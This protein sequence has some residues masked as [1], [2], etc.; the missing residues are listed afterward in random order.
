M[1]VRTTK[2]GSGNIAVQIVENST[3]KVNVIKHIGTG[4]SP[5]Q[6][7]DLKMLAL[8]YISKQRIDAG[9]MSFFEESTLFSLDNLVINKAYKR[10]AYEFFSHVYEVNGFHSITDN[11]LKDLS[12]MRIIEPV[13]KEQS[14]ELMIKYFG[15]GYSYSTIHR[16]LFK[17]CNLKDEIELVA[18]EYARKNLNFDF[19]LVF[20]DVTTLYFETFKGDDL[21]KPGFSKDNK[22]IQ[23]QILI[24]L[25][26][27]TQGYPIGIEMFEGNKFEGHTFIPSILKLKEK[28]NIT[29]LTVVADAAMISFDNIKQL[30]SIGI[31]FIVGARLSKVDKQTLESISNDLNSR[32]GVY[33]SKDTAYGKLICDYSKKRASKDKSDREKQIR[34]AKSHIVRPSQARKPR[35]VKL[36]QKENLE[37]NHQLIAFDVLKEGIKGYYTN[38]KDVPE[39]LIVSRYH[40]LWHVEKSFRI[41]KSDLKA[42]PMFHRKKEMIL[43]HILIVFVSLCMSKSIEIKTGYSI[44]KVRDSVID[45]LDIEFTDKLTQKRVTKRMEFPNLEIYSAL[46]KI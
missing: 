14:I 43:A 31:S 1:K 36:S 11:L 13:S 37:L 2:T 9:E 4:R 20:Y 28:Y 30:S 8:E 42:R 18:V 39:N 7:E 29:T 40:D 22:S 19:S 24:A 45:I 35:F 27:N 3:H 33:I 38:L 15:I 23:P 10:F 44:K 41:A 6:V 17:I 5:Q 16:G 34:K 26:V 32:E 12:I 25:V 46:L 21:R